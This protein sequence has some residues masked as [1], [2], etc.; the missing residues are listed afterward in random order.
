M[1]RPTSGQDSVFPRKAYRVAPERE[2]CHQGE[3]SGGPSGCPSAQHTKNKAAV[4]SCGRRESDTEENELLA[5]GGSA[6]PGPP[7]LGH[8]ELQALCSL[9][10][11]AHQGQLW[12][13]SL[14]V[15]RSQLRRCC[16]HSV[17]HSQHYMQ[18]G[19]LLHWSV[20]YR[21]HIL[22]EEEDGKMG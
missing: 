21:L 14:Q 2:E 15:E 16:E 8:G 6:E 12:L 19:P 3:Q 17:I 9:T 1:C 10:S 11:P 4:L 7:L 5:G 20:F 18:P 22:V 13:R